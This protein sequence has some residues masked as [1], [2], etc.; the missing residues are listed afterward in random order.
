MMSIE[1]LGA[2]SENAR[3]VAYRTYDPVD[4]ILWGIEWADVS[5]IQV[6]FGEP[7]FSSGNV[8]PGVPA[9][10]S[11]GFNAYE[12]SRFLDAF[13]RIEAVANITFDVTNYSVFADM[14][15]TLDT[16][17]LEYGLLGY[18]TLPTGSYF[19]TA[20]GV[21]NGSEWDRYAGGNL[22]PRGEGFATITHEVLHGLGFAHAHDSGGTSTVLDGVTD[23]FYSY[24]THEL[25]QGVYTTQSYNGGWNTGPA[26]TGLPFFGS[27]GTEEGG[28]NGAGYRG[29]KAALRGQYEGGHGQ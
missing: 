16:N 29:A 27:Y 11:E 28:A 5:N 25:N 24:G 6:Y 17:E 23:A 13:A 2:S 21:F 15:L 1:Q 14:E 10:T 12:E 26:G 20:V 9:V 18:F 22:E 8:V 19:D 7:G 4:S 3:E